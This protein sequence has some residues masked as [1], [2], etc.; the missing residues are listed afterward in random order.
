[1]RHAGSPCGLS[2]SSLPTPILGPPSEKFAIQ[3]CQAHQ[4]ELEPPGRTYVATTRH[5]EAGL[6]HH[7]GEQHEIAAPESY[8]S[9]PEEAM[10]ETPAPVESP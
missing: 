9:L 3:P 5:R 1:M 2:Q 4:A 6:I 10:V 7:Y 8:L